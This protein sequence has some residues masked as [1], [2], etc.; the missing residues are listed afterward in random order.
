VVAISAQLSF[1]SQPDTPQASMHA[2]THA[3]NAVQ[4]ANRNNFKHTNTPTLKP[5]TLNPKLQLWP[6]LVFASSSVLMK[7]FFANLAEPF[8]PKLLDGISF[9]FN[10]RLESLVHIF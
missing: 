3:G 9:V 1:A 6:F 10:M 8:L 5:Q 7:L 2:R 4:A